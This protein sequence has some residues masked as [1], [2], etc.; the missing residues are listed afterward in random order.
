MPSVPA[1]R[2]WT[3]SRNRAGTMRRM[4]RFWRMVISIVVILCVLGLASCTMWGE[5]K[6]HT[7]KSA[8]SGEHL[9][10]LFWQ[11]VKAKNW[12]EVEGRMTATVVGMNSRGSLTREQMMEHLKQMDIADFQIGEVRTEAAG[13]DL[14]V[15]YT[16]TVRGTVGGKALPESIRMMSVWQE[17]NNGWVLIAHSAVP[18]AA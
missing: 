5:K 4:L 13:V 18:A 1:E 6:N 11:E 12:K 14:V 3:E 17:L 15:T 8:T 2:R 10:R 9:A 16:L 7:W